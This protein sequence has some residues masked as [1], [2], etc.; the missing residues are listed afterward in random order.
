MSMAFYCIYCG[1]GV[2]GDARFCFKC[3]KAL[4]GDSTTSE[5]AQIEYKQVYLDWSGKA[6]I[7][8]SAGNNDEQQAEATAM[9]RIEDELRPYIDEGWALEGS[10]DSAVKVERK[11]PGTGGVVYTGA[12]VK[13]CRDCEGC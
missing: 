4:K 10:F 6:E 3:G 13:L 1:T 2:P 7:K 12:S 5:N 8:F 9:Q 11:T